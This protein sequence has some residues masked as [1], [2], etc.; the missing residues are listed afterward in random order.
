MMKTPD[1]L[2]KDVVR[3]LFEPFLSFFLPAL[4]NSVDFNRGYEFLDKELD[5]LFTESEQ[6]NRRT[7]DLVKVFLKNGAEQWILVH[8]EVQGYK[9]KDFPLRMFNYYYRIFDRFQRKIVAIAIFTDEDETYFP[10]RYEYDYFGTSLVY[11][12]NAYKVLAQ[13]DHIPALEDSDNPFALVVL[14]ALGSI[15]AKTKKDEEFAYQFKFRLIRLLLQKSFKKDTIL[16]IFIFIGGIIRLSEP[17]ELKY[18]NEMHALVFQKEDA[19]PLSIEDTNL[20]QV[21]M[22]IARR[23]GKR[24][25]IE[26]GKREGIEEGKRE[27]K[28]EGIEE[29]KREGIEEVAANMLRAGMTIEQVVSLSGL[30]QEAVE[31]LLNE[32]TH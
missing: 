13:K 7:D 19:M 4:Y 28:R 15:T 14:A 27:G 3:E 17:L 8:I 5:K 26:E 30:T 24:E 2:W 21:K 25:G 22:N 6:K 1:T 16:K 12:Y 18:E 20:F 10:T 29:G 11:S 9:D 31:K 23:E 32:Q